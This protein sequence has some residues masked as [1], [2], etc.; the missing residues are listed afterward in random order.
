MIIV[1]VEG[2]EDNNNKENHT[3]YKV[4]EHSRSKQATVTSDYQTEFKLNDEIEPAVQRG[5]L[6]MNKNKNAEQL[7]IEL[8]GGAE[9]ASVLDIHANELDENLLCT[10]SRDVPLTTLYEPMQVDDSPLKGL[11]S[12]PDTLPEIPTEVDDVVCANPANTGLCQ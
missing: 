12:R 4:N 2:V 1:D 11:A 3:E 10:P 6:T 8:L 7:E 9:G 5:T